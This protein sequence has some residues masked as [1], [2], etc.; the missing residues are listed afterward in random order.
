MCDWYCLFHAVNFSHFSQ[1]PNKN[2]I[3]QFAQIATRQT[4]PN[5]EA[6][7]GNIFTSWILQRKMCNIKT[8]QNLYFTC[9]VFKKNLR[10]W[11]FEGITLIFNHNFDGAFGWLNVC[12]L[13]DFLMKTERCLSFKT[14]IWLHGHLLVV[15]KWLQ[16]QPSCLQDILVPRFGTFFRSKKVI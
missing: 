5:K 4:S 7:R 16:R 2:I 14:H 3:F 10:K 8:T 12:Y 15:A 11:I 1:I 6:K 13:Q 9:T